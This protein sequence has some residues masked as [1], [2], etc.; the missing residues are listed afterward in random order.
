MSLPQGR[1]HRA[2]PQLVARQQQNWGVPGA[3]HPPSPQHTYV[4]V[5]LREGLHHVEPVHVHDGRVDGELGPEQAVKETA[6]ATSPEQR[7]QPPD[8]PPGRAA[9]LR[10][11]DVPGSPR[12][13]PPCSPAPLPELPVSPFQRPGLL[14]RIPKG[15]RLSPPPSPNGRAGLSPLRIPPRNPASPSSLRTGLY[16]PN[17]RS[18]LFPRLS[19]RPSP[20]RPAAAI[21]QA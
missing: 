2:T 11:R 12:S 15:A 18:R 6:P 16:S 10:R 7:S 3:P 19:P 8:K 20:P 14:C 1:S 21:P 9:L 5:E 4:S 13:G 17:D